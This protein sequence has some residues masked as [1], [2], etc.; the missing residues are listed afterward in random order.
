MKQL[1]VFEWMNEKEIQPGERVAITLVPNPAY[2]EATNRLRPEGRSCWAATQ[3]KE[4]S[5]CSEDICWFGGCKH[6]H[7]SRKFFAVALTCKE[8]S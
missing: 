2:G 7:L 1:K 5:L 6:H 8:N 3:V 4:L